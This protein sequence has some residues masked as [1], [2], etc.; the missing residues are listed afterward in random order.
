M[1]TQREILYTKTKHSGFSP[2]MCA[3]RSGRIQT[4][5]MLIE[6]GA[7]VNE[8]DAYDRDAAMYLAGAGLYGEKLY[9]FMDELASKEDPRTRAPSHSRSRSNNHSSKHGSMC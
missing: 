9:S 1:R 2:L 8:R 7:D 6:L 5:R 4:A 3:V